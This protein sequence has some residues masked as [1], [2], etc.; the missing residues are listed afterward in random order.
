MSKLDRYAEK[1][2]KGLKGFLYWWL[3]SENN[4]KRVYV[5]LI[6]L[7]IIFI[8]VIS[9]FFELFFS[10]LNLPNYLFNIDT[11]LT[12][13]F[14][15]E[16]LTRFY[17]SSDFIEDIKDE[18]G[19]IIYAITNKVKWILSPFPIIDLVSLIPIIRFLRF[20]RTCRLLRFI[21][22]LKFIRLLKVKK[23]F[24]NISILVR[25]FK[26]SYFLIA[27]LLLGTLFIVIINSFALFL[28]ESQVGNANSYF[29][30]LNYTLKL[31]GICD[32]A[33]TTVM[34]KIFSSFTLIA[35]ISF[36]SFFISTISTKS[37]EI[38]SNIKK[39]KLG[40]LTIKDH[41]VLCGYTSS[42]SKVIE[43]ILKNKKLYSKRIVLVTEKENPS[44]NGIIYFN[45]DYSSIDTLRKVN[46]CDCSL[47]VIFAEYQGN[48]PQ[49]NVDMRTVLT[50]FN[51]E[52]ENKN[53]HT[54][55]EIINQENSEIIR[56]KIKGD[57]IIYKE[58]IDANLI[59][60]CIRHPY[61]SPLLYEMLNLDG[62]VIKENKLEHFGFK[63]PVKFKE[64]K[65]YQIDQDIN[66]I[67]FIAENND[68]QLA[69]KNDEIIALADRIIYLE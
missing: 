41:I 57:E 36:I 32:D 50:V 10:D 68:A 56:D 9:T 31:V 67:G 63:E 12:V 15:I 43:E 13:F 47:A 40:K 39:G 48:E 54:I 69:P 49:K 18:D 60:N 3:E 24:S 59:S 4:S 11:S 26:E 25:S 22:F 6:L 61:I 14:A 37:G 20:F 27:I 42:T 46:I 62:R 64:L 66:I 5:D 34:G 65:Q 35:N 33:P 58:S 19:S 51:I 55:A 2:Q 7:L 52:Q 8:S 44:L 45:G 23:S 38:M 17:I 21:K 16:Y 30:Y 28:S 1:Q 53:V 29:H